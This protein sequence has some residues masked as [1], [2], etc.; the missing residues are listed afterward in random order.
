MIEVL[1]LQGS[2]TLVLSQRFE[3]EAGVAQNY[4][5]LSL[6]PTIFLKNRKVRQSKLKW[7][8]SINNSS[9]DIL[10]AYGDISR[11]RDDFQF[12]GPRK[13]GKRDFLGKVAKKIARDEARLALA[14]NKWKINIRRLPRIVSGPRHTC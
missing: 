8:T 6:W 14:D 12:S 1:R 13:V 10:S 3:Q 9:P 11:T 2:R 7:R 5:A 4:E